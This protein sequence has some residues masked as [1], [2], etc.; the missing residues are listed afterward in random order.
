MSGDLRRG[1]VLVGLL[2]GVGMLKVAQ[3]TALS[4]TAYRV[5]RA[6]TAWHDLDNDTMWLRTQVQ[7]L[8]S[9]I[10]LAKTMRA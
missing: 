5:G 7:S 8:G 4:L 3:Q 1:L 6:Y 9:P 2:T 10:A